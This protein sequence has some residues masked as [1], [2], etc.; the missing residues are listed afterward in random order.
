MK[1]SKSLKGSKSSKLSKR[2]KT[3]KSTKT[4]KRLARKSKNGSVVRKMRGGVDP[5]DVPRATTNAI[6][7][8][9]LSSLPDELIPNLITDLQSMV[10]LSQTNKQFQTLINNDLMHFINS[11]FEKFP[12]IEKKFITIMRTNMDRFKK[13]KLA[14]IMLLFK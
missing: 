4:K 5:D 3:R 11:G 9:T 1:K 12:P 8:I 13:L 10:N 6:N 2:V 14:E 7:P